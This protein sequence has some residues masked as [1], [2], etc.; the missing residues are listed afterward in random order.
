MS[1]ANILD[2]DAFGRTANGAAMMFTNAT[3][4]SLAPLIP[5]E[6]IKPKMI[7]SAPGIATRFGELK[8]LRDGWLDGDGKAPSHEGLDWLAGII[9]SLYSDNLPPPYVYP[10]PEG[11]VQLEWSLDGREIS[12]EVDLGSKTGE[13]HSFDLSTKDE[14][15]KRFDLA[16]ATGWSEIVRRLRQ[17]GGATQ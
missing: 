11:G 1:R 17:A 3:V 10:T 6:P 8:A 15:L 5:P 16:T 12:L 7:R 9:R 14:E 4:F 13:W 2:P